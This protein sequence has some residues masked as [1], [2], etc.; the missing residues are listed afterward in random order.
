MGVRLLGRDAL[1]L[2]DA[3]ET[4][5]PGG[6]PRNVLLVGR[7]S[8]S[9][10]RAL[11]SIPFVRLEVA[12]VWTPE[13]PRPDLTVMNATLPT[14][15]PPGPL[16]VVDP[17]VTSARLVGVGLGSAARV[18][19]DHPLLQGLDLAALRAETPTISGVPGWARVVLG[20][21]QGPLVMEGR[22]EG[23]PALVL[24]L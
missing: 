8:A 10:R 17:P 16:L 23:R 18:Q 21:R 7:A 9:L 24:T 14:Q 5:A 1:A 19:D 6:P 22:L 15:L 20:T 3:A 13:R 11:E 4:I 12:D 2:D